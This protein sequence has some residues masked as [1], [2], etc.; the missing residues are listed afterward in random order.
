MQLAGTYNEESGVPASASM[1]PRLVETVHT[2][3]ATAAPASTASMG[4]T[5]LQLI[6]P[7]PRTASPCFR[8]VQ[9]AHAPAPVPK[10]Y[11]GT[12]ATQT[13]SSL[14]AAQPSLLPPNQAGSVN[15]TWCYSGSSTPIAPGP[16]VARAPLFARSGSEE[17]LLAWYREKRMG[18]GKFLSAS[19]KDSQLGGAQAW[20]NN[21]IQSREKAPSSIVQHSSTRPYKQ[22]QSG[23]Q[24]MHPLF[25]RLLKKY[26]VKEDQLARGSVPITETEEPNSPSLSML[27]LAGWVRKKL[28]SDYGTLKVAALVAAIQ[29][30]LCTAQEV[31]DHL[32]I[33]LK[34]SRGANTGVTALPSLDEI[35][36]ELPR[37][38]FSEAEFVEALVGVLNTNVTRRS[39]ERL[40]RLLDVE[41]IGAVE[42]SDLLHWDKLALQAW[43]PD[44]SSISDGGKDEETIST[45]MSNQRSKKS[46]TSVCS[47]D[48]DVDKSTE[49]RKVAPDT[50]V[51]LSSSFQAGDGA[52]V[53][54]RRSSPAPPRRGAAPAQRA[55]SHTCPS[56]KLAQMIQQ[57]SEVGGTVR[58]TEEAQQALKAALHDNNSPSPAAAAAEGGSQPQGGACAGGGAAAGQD[59]VGKQRERGS[60]VDRGRASLGHTSGT[61]SVSVRRARGGG[62]DGARYG[63]SVSV[64]RPATSGTMTPISNAEPP[65]D[66]LGG[67]LP[68]LGQ[69]GRRTGVA[70]RLHSSKGPPGKR[71]KSPGH[72]APAGVTPSAGQP[73]QAG[74]P[75]TATPQR[76]S[77]P[78]KHAPAHSS[79][80][81]SL[82]LSVAAGSSSPAGPGF[83]KSLE[84]LQSLQSLQSLLAFKQEVLAQQQDGGCEPQQRKAESVGSDKA[85]VSTTAASVECLAPL[86]AA[87]SSSCTTNGHACLEAADATATASTTERQPPSEHQAEV[88]DLHKGTSKG[89]APSVQRE[90]LEV[91]GSPRRHSFSGSPFVSEPVKAARI[92]EMAG[93]AV[94]RNTIQV[95]QAGCNTAPSSW[96]VARP[97]PTESL[98]SNVAA[99]SMLRYNVACR[100]ATT[101]RPGSAQVA[102]TTP[103]VPEV[104][105]APP[106]RSH[107][108]P[109][110]QKILACRAVPTATFTTRTAAVAAPSPAYVLRQ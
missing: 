55:A 94:S 82:S 47:S 24:A 72:V 17:A 28:A 64:K 12:A 4:R 15:A 36:S 63:G 44:T 27:E 18:G 104:V 67:S 95:P 3:V 78:A 58:L 49:N 43:G 38:K 83:A 75:R 56:A 50:S 52:A 26:G 89:S 91:C 23:S 29:M 19:P 103:P 30:K 99:A 59:K 40:F 45:A 65:K 69:H 80:A 106:A 53:P 37:V 6:A 105:Q 61:G 86:A 74:S 97:L 1:Q 100:P 11:P 20:H 33:S 88:V 62:Q 92:V 79:L 60:S 71:S 5:E 57:Q 10:R 48:P 84:A 66:P 35:E 85:T 87:G 32:Q 34:L 73:P 31:D 2:A 77:S 22:E 7:S 110:A 101:I 108:L 39:A 8:M 16:H 70:S 21:A 51:V 102:S 107:V 54:S 109:S 96:G 41:R 42:L 14:V 98:A 13:V 93:A 76:H 46:Q 25:A 9:Q 90:V 81:G 68:G